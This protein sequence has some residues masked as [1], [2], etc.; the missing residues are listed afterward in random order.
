MKIQFN[1]DL[2]HQQEAIA[3]IGKHLN[4]DDPPK[5]ALGVRNQAGKTADRKC[6]L[7]RSGE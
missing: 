6:K 7:R 3:S 1:P 2:E 4:A 5:S